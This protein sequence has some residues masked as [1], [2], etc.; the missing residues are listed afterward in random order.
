ML[1][2]ELVK[3]FR[4][5]LS[6]GNSVFPFFFT[7]LISAKKKDAF[8]AWS[9]VDPEREQNNLDIAEATNHLY[10]TVIPAVAAKLDKEYKNFYKEAHYIIDF[11]H[12]AGVN[13]RHL[14]N[15]GF[16]LFPILHISDFQLPFFLYFQGRVRRLVESSQVREDILLEVTCG[17]VVCVVV[18]CCA[19]VW[20][21]AR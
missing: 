9:R 15:F 20:S 3:S 18:V 19:V 1:R 2:P 8:T 7:V 13:L 4:K 5:P 11:L 6:S 12:P 21:C 10:K 17:G 16:F 14:G